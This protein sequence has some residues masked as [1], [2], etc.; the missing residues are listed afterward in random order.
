MT[1]QL[2]KKDW[3]NGAKGIWS[4]RP[5]KA[6]DKQGGIFQ[7][8]RTTSNTLAGDD[9]VLG[10]ST[11]TIG[12]SINGTLKT[13]AGSD[14]IK[15]KSNTEQGI[16]CEGSINTG[17]DNDS[18]TGISTDSRGLENQG[19]IYTEDGNDKITGKS[20]SQEG[21]TNSSYIDMGEGSDALKAAGALSALRNDGY[22]NMGSGSDLVNCLKGGFSG[23]GEIDM[24]TGFDTVIGFGAQKI[25]GGG[26]RDTLL[27][28]AG[29]YRITNYTD[30]WGYSHGKKI[31]NEN[32]VAMIVDSFET[33]GSAASKQQ[34]DLSNGTL[35]INAM[36]E[37]TYL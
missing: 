3:R 1:T 6:K 21:L 10:S 11:S 9:A 8:S 33:I 28:D 36:G 12:T 27:L 37:A 7:T 25:Y 22:I 30:E 19:Y 24:G 35:L 4:K 32:N 34:L 16:Y 29:R 5:N 2:T 31:T 17:L 20:K 14:K 13:Q 15:G 18:I 23:D 26:D